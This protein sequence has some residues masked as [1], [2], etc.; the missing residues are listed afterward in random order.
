MKKLRGF[1]L[2]ELVL[3]ITLFTLM[4]TV[5]GSLVLESVRGSK[6]QCLRNTS[7]YLIKETYNAISITKGDLWS[8]IVNNSGEGAKHLEF[9]DNKYVIQ[10]GAIAQDG[11]NLQFTIDIA[12]RD[13]TGNI[14]TVGGNP[15]VHTRV[16][17][18]NASWNDISGNANQIDSKIFMNDWNTLDWQQTTQEDFTAGTT[19]GTVVSNTS[20][21]EVQLQRV[22][23][24]DWC[25]PTLAY[26][27]YDIPGAATAKTLFSESG[28]TYLGTGGSSNGVALTKLRIEGVE[29]PTITVEG[30][31][32]GYLTNN[33]FA[34]GNYAY[35]A[36]TQDNKEVVIL[37]ISKTPFTEVGYFNTSR[38]EDA[39]S[40]WVVGNVGYVAAGRYV[41]SFDLTSKT[42]SRTQLGL[43]QV[44]QNQNFMQT[45]TVS[46]IAVRGNYL[47]AALDQDWYEMSIVN[48]SNPA[49]MTITSQTNVNNQQSF[50]IYISE[51]GNRT[52]FGTGNSTSEREFFIIDT[53][54]KSGS[55]PIIGSYDTNGMSVKGIA[56]VERDKRAVLV[57]F[58]AEEYQS[59]NIAVE[60]T[61]VRCGGMQLNAGINDVDSVIDNDGNAFSYLLINDSSNDFKVL[62]GGPG[63]GGDET[64][65]GFL[66][67]G[68]FT[69]SVFDSTSAT[70]NFYYVQ[71]TG[72][73]PANT[74]I[75]VQ[76]RAGTTA[77]LSSQPWLGPDGTGSSYFPVN[78]VT[79]FP[80]AFSGKRYIQYRLVF[81]SDLLST[82]RFD[83]ITINYQK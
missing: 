38:T 59:V 12:Y 73:I 5:V 53:S 8:E 71:W 22:F 18:I 67:S 16:I 62:R 47:Y 65:Y 78:A 28:T 14:V 42:G 29:D 70:T 21:G 4:I 20:G 1:S 6:N 9:I 52:Y 83:Q 23:F 69:S 79:N 43:K 31:F 33:I 48:I 41:F 57:G 68:E 15:D 58:N 50:D 26:N 64:G 17:T 80:P 81:S 36:T 82:P 72:N 27:D 77:D 25:R 63:L 35:L 49:N 32:N 37:D 61:P 55:R 39:N 46:Q 10:D 75:Q 60:T 11:V 19:N 3:A 13:A 56:I 45:A 7:I 76:F 44:S 66:D 2:V 40:V 74:N 54:S 51:D 30:D 24:P 34:S